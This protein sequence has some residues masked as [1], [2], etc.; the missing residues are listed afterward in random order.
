MDREDLK[1]FI[2]R[3]NGEELAFRPAPD[4]LGIV[5][6]ENGADVSIEEDGAILY[7]REHKPLAM[8][9]MELY[10]QVLE[11]MPAFRKAPQHNTARFDWLDDT[12]TL[13]TFGNCELAAN[14]FSD[15]SMQF[16]TWKLDRN[17]ARE[18]GH[19]YSD[20]NDAKQDFAFRAELI[21][22]DMLFSEK[23]L[24]V[25]RS[26]LSDYLASEDTFLSGRQEDAV[27][28]VISK[29]DNII[30]PEIQENAEEKEVELGYEPEQ[31][32]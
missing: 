14:R 32:L 23:E 2:R 28:E 17:G 10:N 19:Y 15:G 9:V 18:T 8:K 27:K 31:E 24:T 6:D 7:K 11:Y 29:I 22:R 16:I 30:A 25:I 20:F 12:R 13:L 26:H 4:G 21:N 3:L 1:E 5:S